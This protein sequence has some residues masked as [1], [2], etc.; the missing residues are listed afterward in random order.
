MSNVQVSSYIA[1]PTEAK[2]LAGKTILVTGSASGLGAALCDVLS[3]AGANIVVGD[4]N[5]DKAQT[6]ASLLEEAGGK[7]YECRQGHQ[8]GAAAGTDRDSR[9]DGVADAGVVMAVKG[10]NAGLKTK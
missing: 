3:S 10:F 7:T 5:L 4:L 6:V 1:D 8:V 9:S 2:Q